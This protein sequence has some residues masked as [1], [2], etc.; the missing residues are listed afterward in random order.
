M[1]DAKYIMEKRMIRPLGTRICV[2]PIEMDAITKGGLHLVQDEKPIQG[3]IIAVGSK[4]TALKVGDKVMYGKYG[5]HE[6]V[7][8]GQKLLILQEQDVM[9]TLKS[10]V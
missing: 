8:E 9:G 3:E 1:D 4:V 6:V 7:V 5:G 10:D 2:K